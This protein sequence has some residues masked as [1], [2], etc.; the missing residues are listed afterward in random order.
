MKTLKLTIVAVVLSFAMINIAAGDG[1]TQK[2]KVVNITF[3]KAIYNFGLAQAMYTQLNDEPLAAEKPIHV[4]RVYHQGSMYM[5]SGT[6]S[7]WSDFFEQWI[8]PFKKKWRS[9]VKSTAFGP[10]II[11]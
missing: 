5:V 3:E 1:L 4:F 10:E 9:K 8:A 2:K 6:T 11:N 7:Q